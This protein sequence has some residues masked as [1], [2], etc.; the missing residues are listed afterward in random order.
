MN[1]SPPPWSVSG[2]VDVPGDSKRA[3]NVH[4][5]T[6]LLS[7]GRTKELIFLMGSTL[8]ETRRLTV[9]YQNVVPVRSSGGHLTLLDLSAPFLF[10][11]R[12]RFYGCK[13]CSDVALREPCAEGVEA[14]DEKMVAEALGVRLLRFVLLMKLELQDATD[15]LDVFLW[16]DAVEGGRA[17]NQEAP[18][19]HPSQ[20]MDNTLC[21]PEGSTG[22]RPWLDLCLT[23]RKL[24]LVFVEEEDETELGVSS[25]RISS[26]VPRPSL[27]ALRGRLRVQKLSLTDLD[28][29]RLGFSSP[30]PPPPPPPP[31]AAAAAAAAESGAAPGRTRTRHLLDT[32]GD[33]VEAARA[34]K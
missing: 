29:P 7:E 8:E 25:G 31:A 20:T 19:K 13:R 28:L 4:L 14:I 30:P 26:P 3:L 10:R 24:L 34:E 33:F 17:A 2:R 18:E 21:P 11:G 15:S 1:P 23:L 6:Q 22:V 9:G 12:K 5:S 32:T 16:R 27:R